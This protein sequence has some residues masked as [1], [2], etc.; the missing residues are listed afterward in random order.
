MIRYAFQY[1]DTLDVKKLATS[2]AQ[3]PVLNSG[4]LDFHI[5]SK[6]L[7]LSR[8]LTLLDG[9]CKTMDETFMYNDIILDMMTDLSIV[10]EY[11]DFDVLFTRSVMDINKTLA[12]IGG[13]AY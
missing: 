7:L 8:A 12:N 13:L 9:T 1:M 11:I 3:D 4:R 10:S 2:I 5:D 6:L